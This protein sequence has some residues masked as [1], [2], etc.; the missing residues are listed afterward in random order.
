MSTDSLLYRRIKHISKGM[1]N[2]RE[3]S[4]KTIIRRVEK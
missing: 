1:K 2:E 3:V 4:M